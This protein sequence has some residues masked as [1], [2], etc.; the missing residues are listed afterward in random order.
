MRGREAS[1]LLNY[2]YKDDSG[3]RIFVAAIVY[4]YIFEIPI[5]AGEKIGSIKYRNM[6]KQDYAPLTNA[7]KPI[8]HL[9]VFFPTSLI[10]LIAHLPA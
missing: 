5:T 10:K 3:K 7:P 8:V 9:L 1:L 4:V 6:L 2:Q